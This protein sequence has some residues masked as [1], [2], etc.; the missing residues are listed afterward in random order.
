MCKAELSAIVEI[1]KAEANNLITNYTD[2]INIC[3]ICLT[4]IELATKLLREEKNK[5]V[6]NKAEI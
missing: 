2:E 3:E 1:I 5:I 4:R 6:D